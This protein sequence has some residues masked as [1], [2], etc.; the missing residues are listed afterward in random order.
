MKLLERLFGMGVDVASYSLQHVI[1]DHLTQMSNE[2]PVYEDTVPFHDIGDS[3]NVVMSVQLISDE[4]ERTDCCY[5]H[6]RAIIQVN[7]FESPACKNAGISAY[8]NTL[9]TRQMQAMKGKTNGY[10]SFSN[11]RQ[12]SAQT[13]FDIDNGW[14][15]RFIDYIVSYNVEI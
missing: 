1:I 9:T 2:L 8:M 5:E 15:R 10:F 7:I 14:K 3:K 12:S 6:H 11:I 4:I 13:D